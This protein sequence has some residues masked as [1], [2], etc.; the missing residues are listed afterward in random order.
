M[1]IKRLMLTRLERMPIF[2]FKQVILSTAFLYFKWS[3]TYSLC[4]WKY[5]LYL[6]PGAAKIGT[7]KSVF[8][9]ILASRSWPHL[10]QVISE[11]HNMH[12]HTLER[13]VKA[14]FSFNAERGLLTICKCHSFLRNSYFLHDFTTLLT[15]CQCN[16]PKTDMN[17]SLI[18][19]IT[20]LMDWAQTSMT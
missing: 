2:C 5:P 3:I 11:Y 16:V 1:R 20:P 17:I 9:S 8:H 12:G 4:Q 18:A 10:R 13:A 14:E 6:F 15:F 19:Y 7:D